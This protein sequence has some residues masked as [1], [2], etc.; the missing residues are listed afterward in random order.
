M[1]SLSWAQLL[2]SGSLESKSKLKL[3]SNNEE[4]ACN[5]A[6]P[7]SIPG[8]EDPLEEELATH[9]RILAWRIPWTGEP[10]GIQSW[11]LDKSD[12]TE[13]LTLHFPLLLQLNKIHG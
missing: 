8:L 9:S 4:S 6:D 12:T 10:G 13:Q 7:G 2:G 11:G 3:G 1:F 5:A